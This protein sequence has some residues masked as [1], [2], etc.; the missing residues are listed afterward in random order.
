MAMFVITRGYI[1]LRSGSLRVKLLLQ[2][3]HPNKQEQTVLAP[4]LRFCENEGVFN[5]EVTSGCETGRESRYPLQKMI[6]VRYLEFPAC[7]RTTL[8]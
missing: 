4:R 8:R 7:I 3:P 2:K 6:S 5:N 1:P